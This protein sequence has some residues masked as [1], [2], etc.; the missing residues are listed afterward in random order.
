MT[1]SPVYNDDEMTIIMNIK[2]GEVHKED[3]NALVQ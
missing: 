2:D 1:P 3:D